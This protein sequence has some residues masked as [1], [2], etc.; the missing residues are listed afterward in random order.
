MW[1]TH[2]GHSGLS[3]NTRYRN[4]IL[5]IKYV[6]NASLNL[7][8]SI[9]EAR[10]TS[11]GSNGFLNPSYNWLYSGQSQFDFHLSSD[12]QKKESPDQI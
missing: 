9:S 3:T 11:W 5:L 1:D 2:T 6:M 7:T 8:S 10:A 12:N 4:F